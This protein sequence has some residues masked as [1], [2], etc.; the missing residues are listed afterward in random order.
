MRNKKQFYKP[1]S[2]HRSPKEIDYP[3]I[4]L[5]ASS[6]IHSSDLPTT[7]APKGAMDE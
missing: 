2:V 6:P 4:S 3:V 1:G 7:A 5:G